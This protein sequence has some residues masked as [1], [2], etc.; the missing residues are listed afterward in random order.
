MVLIRPENPADFAAIEAVNAAAF[1][2]PNEARLVA[3]LRRA[4]AL[5]LSLVAVDAEAIVGHLAFSPVRVRAEAGDWEAVGLGPVAVAPARQK[6]GIGARLTTAG[7]AACLAAGQDVV[8]V[9]G[10]AHYY[11]RFGFRPS[12]PLGIR[13]EIDVP[14]EVFMVAELRPGAL[15]GRTGVVHYRPEFASV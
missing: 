11:P 2:R 3:E 5:T 7:L 6:Q 4:G 10:H 13:W 9:L 14:A 8:I 12:Q 1:G 15:A